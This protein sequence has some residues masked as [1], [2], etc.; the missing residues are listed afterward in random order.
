VAGVTIRGER[1]QQGNS[2][3]SADK[4]RPIRPR[5]ARPGHLAA[6]YGDFVAQDDEFDVLGCATAGKQY[7]PAEQP[8]RDEIQ[9]S[10]QHGR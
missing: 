3:V 8:E 9:Q 6:Q 5:Q 1:S 2:Q 10:E 4:I 7:K